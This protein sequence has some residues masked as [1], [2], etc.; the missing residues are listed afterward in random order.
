MSFNN[1]YINEII[2]FPY[3]KN[4]EIKLLWGFLPSTLK[5]KVQKVPF[6]FILLLLL[7]AKKK[8]TLD[9]KALLLLLH[10]G[11][12]EDFILGGKGYDKE[13]CFICDAIRIHRFT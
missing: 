7:I 4:V 11:D 5:T 12:D 8:V 9:Y 3:E 1:Q 2:D 10:K 13:F 6:L